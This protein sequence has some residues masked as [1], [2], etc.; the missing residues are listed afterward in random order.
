[1]NDAPAA[2][3]K[4]RI[5]VVIPAYEVARHIG[6]VI[7][8]VPD[9][10][11]RIILVDDASQD[12]TADRAAEV[13]D[14]RLCVLRHPENRGVGAATLT[15]MDQAA[16]EGCTIIVKMDGDGQMD[17]GMIAELVRPI[18]DGEADFV[19]GNRFG[20]PGTIRRMPRMRRAGNLALSFLTKISS[21]CWQVFDPTNGFFAMDASVYSRLNKGLIHRRYFFEISLLFALNLQGA[22]LHNVTMPAYYGDELS[23]MSLGRVL[24]EFPSLLG[25]Q[26]SRRIWLQYFVLGFSVASLFLVAGVFLSAFGTVWGAAAWAKSLREGIPATTGTVMISVLPLILGFELLIQTI[27]FDVTRVP[28]RPQSRLWRWRWQR[29]P[30]PGPRTS[31]VL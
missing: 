9:A 15:G 1:M 24:W 12:G 26:F 16:A 14:P 23:S 2:E 17:P 29:P 31:A 22:V 21:G 8:G 28:T 25:R 4:E 19:K 13:Q 18:L 30:V 11:D 7:R 27:V 3:F 5:G 6:Q 10:V 20:D